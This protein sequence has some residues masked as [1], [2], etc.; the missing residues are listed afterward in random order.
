[1]R[2]REK[3]QCIRETNYI[4]QV[5]DL[6]ETKGAIY[7]IYNKNKRDRRMYVGETTGTI[8][9]RLRGHWNKGRLEMRRHGKCTSP[10][11]QYMQKVGLK[12]IAVMCAELVEELETES[13]EEYQTRLRMRENG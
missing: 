13:R 1:M 5:E 10:I 11:D 3:L 4:D 6:P 2:L 7:I 9:D 8:I 12:T